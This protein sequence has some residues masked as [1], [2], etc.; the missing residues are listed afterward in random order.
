V[1]NRRPLWLRRLALLETGLL[2]TAAAL[3]TGGGLLQI[4][5]RNLLQYSVPWLDPL[6]RQLVLVITMLGAVRAADRGVHLRLDPGLS[7][8]PE[9]WS[10]RVNVLTASLA[11]LVCL[12]L[13]VASWRFL[14]L[15]FAVHDGTSLSRSFLWIL[16]VG[17][18]LLTFH[19]LVH[20]VYP[21]A[22]G[23]KS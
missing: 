3:L 8:L 16:P 11:A 20:L 18:A 5:L 10:G 6:Q 13:A 9:P 15:S 7:L 19:F 12:V 23:R 14:W 1:K 4:L 22:P 17:F 2:V 21:A